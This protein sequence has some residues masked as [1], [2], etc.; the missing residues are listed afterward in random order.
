MGSTPFIAGA[1]VAGLAAV[2]VV[3]GLSIAVCRLKN[4]GIP[5]GKV[6]PKF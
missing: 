4:P 3:T 6:A 5:T 1:A 2:S